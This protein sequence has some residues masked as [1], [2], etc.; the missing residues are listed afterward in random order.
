M[1][2]VQHVCDTCGTYLPLPYATRMWTYASYDAYVLHTL[3]YVLHTSVAR[4]RHS[5]T[6]AERMWTYAGAADQMCQGATGTHCC[7]HQGHASTRGHPEVSESAVSRMHPLQPVPPL[8]HGCLACMHMDTYVPRVRHVCICTGLHTCR[9][10]MHTCH[11]CNTYARVE[12]GLEAHM[13]TYVLR[14]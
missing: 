13:S 10:R 8:A 7:A 6:Y 2:R 3:T 9:I 5:V 1:P 4:M 12:A 11:L 14:T